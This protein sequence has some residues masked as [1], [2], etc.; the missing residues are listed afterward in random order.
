M[1]KKFLLLIALG[2]P[3]TAHAEIVGLSTPQG[4]E[5][6]R[7]SASDPE[8]LRLFS[9]V[10]TEF[11]RRLCGPTSVAIALNSLGIHDPTPAPMFP[12]HLLTQETVFTPENLKVKSYQKV[13]EEGLTLDE[14][15]LFAEH[16]GVKAEAIHASADV[17]KDT[18]RDKIRSALVTPGIR[19]IVN[20]AR[21]ALQQQTPDESGDG[22]HI[23]PIAAYDAP[24]DSFLVMD[25][26]RYKPYGPVWIT[27]DDF[28]RAMELVDKASTLP[29]GILIVSRPAE[30]ATGA[31]KADK[32]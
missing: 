8:T 12:Y 3:L 14:L 18:L 28:L 9:F 16:L 4:A 20:Y 10:E 30:A 7:R 31:A 13:M 2:L 21:K 29:R 22:G 17:P 32:P 24:S 6:F 11:H 25:V 27:F 26:A 15:R 5:R 23:S 19:V 1:L